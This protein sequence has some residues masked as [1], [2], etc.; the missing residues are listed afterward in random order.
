MK[1]PTDDFRSS[2][3]YEQRRHDAP[4]DAV[5]HKFNKWL[6]GEMKSEDVTFADGVRPTHLKELSTLYEHGM[7]ED[8]MFKEQKAK[9]GK[10]RTP[11]EQMV[12]DRFF[13]WY[14]ERGA[15]T[16]WE[17]KR[18]VEERRQL[19]KHLHADHM[20]NCLVGGCTCPHRHI[21]DEEFKA[22]DI[23]KGYVNRAVNEH[24][25][26]HKVA[27]AP[28]TKPLFD[29]PNNA[30]INDKGMTRGEL[31]CQ[32]RKINRE[33]K[34]KRAAAKQACLHH[35]DGW[36][37]QNVVTL[38]HYK[39]EYEDVEALLL[40][41]PRPPGK[42]AGDVKWDGTR[43]V[44]GP[45][46]SVVRR[47]RGQCWRKMCTPAN[48]APSARTDQVLR[49]VLRDQDTQHEKKCQSRHGNACNCLQ[50]LLSSD[51]ARE[52]FNAKVNAQQRARKAKLRSSNTDWIARNKEQYSGMPG[53]AQAT[54]ATRAITPSRPA[55][56]RHASRRRVGGARRTVA[57]VDR[58]PADM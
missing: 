41:K 57:R 49:N 58:Q 7:L 8:E 11:P 23:V 32:R 10:H 2:E 53:R 15:Q 56:S 28:L 22:A 51:A 54:Q 35:K 34:K 36:K 48:Q 18:D 52:A 21:W 29:L 25:M 3:D 27:A 39:E 40:L 17:K 42:D 12:S 30:A 33:D 26:S 47:K 24:R 45:E 14:Y 38:V 5:R 43:V 6:R 44:G 19:A 20:N 9:L 31:L 50:R 46:F 16:F 13:R 1:T 4:T 37:S 55:A